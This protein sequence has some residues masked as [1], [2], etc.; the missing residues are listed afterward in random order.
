[1]IAGINKDFI[2]RCGLEE[3]RSQNA[4]ILSRSCFMSVLKILTYPDPILRKKANP[5]EVIDG[6]IEKL[7]EDMAE[8][9]YA[10]PGI[11]LAAPQVGESL[12]VITLDATR[13]EKGLIVLINPEIISSEGECA[14][15]EGC[16]SIPDFKEAIP[17][18][19]KILVKG[20]DTSGKERQIPAEGL[21]AIG[22]QHEIDHLDGI[23]IIDRISRL[24]RDFFKKKLRNL[25]VHSSS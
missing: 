13:E 4:E 18:K 22:F 8:T 11:G 10:A 17:R 6:R 24:K 5:V 15:E 14:E 7:V 21:L 9:M 20:L 25:R 19:K 16:L 3:V 2:A 23:L 12:R 1:M